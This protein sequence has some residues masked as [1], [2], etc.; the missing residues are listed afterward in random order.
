L[1]TWFRAD[2]LNWFRDRIPPVTHPI[3]DHWGVLE[4]IAFDLK[5]PLD[6]ATAEGQIG[7]A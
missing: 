2:L 3:A 1:E 4:A 7:D 5:A 6:E